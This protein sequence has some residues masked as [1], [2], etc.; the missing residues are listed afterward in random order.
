MTE[1]SNFILDNGIRCVHRRVKSRAAYCSLSINSGTRDELESEHG[2]AHLTEHL[3]FRGTSKLSS[4]DI[5]KRLECRGGDLNAYTGKEE[6]VI[7]AL[8]LRGD[9][10]RALELI[11]QMIFD[12]KFAEKDIESEKEIIFD[13]INSYKDSPSELI[14]DDFEELLFAGSNIGRNI[15]GDKKKLKKISRDSILEYTGRNFASCQ[16]VISSCGDIS[17]ERF[18]DICTKVFGSIERS[19]IV[20]ERVVPKRVE[21]FDV[22]IHKKTFQTH[23]LIGGYAPNAKTGGRIAVALLNNIIGGPFSMSLLNQSLRERRSITYN[24]ESSYTP[25]SDCGFFAIYYSCAEEKNAKARELI[26]KELKGLREDL[27]SE[28]KFNRFKKQFLG[29]LVIS[30]ENQESMMLAVAKSIALFGEFE[31]QEAIYKK[32][33]NISQQELREAANLIYNEDNLYMLRYS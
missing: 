2:V 1:Y 18:R 11:K 28:N 27:M 3:L 33:D 14:F 21:L 17:H 4:Y 29:Q 16:M 8:S 26:M 10:G 20:S 22:D 24:V 6:T 7:H 19:E 31:S 12:S 15:L 9:F 30:N 25:Y 5:S 13:E 23:G 32:I